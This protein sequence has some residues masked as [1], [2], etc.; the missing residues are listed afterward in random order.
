MS[1]GS[2]F[3]RLE[4]SA[5][6]ILSE[7]PEM[8]EVIDE[9]NSAES[10]GGRLEV[11]LTAIYDKL[12]EL[13]SNLLSAVI[14]GIIGWYLVKLMI[15]ACKKLLTKTKLEHAIVDFLMSIIRVFLRIVL[16]VI[17]ATTLGFEMSS[18]VALIASA[19]LAISLALQG[20]LTNFAGGLL[21]LATKPFVVGDYIIDGGGNEGK[22]TS[23]DIIYTHLLTPDNCAVVIPNGTLANSVIT[24][25]TREAVRRV[26][27]QVSID[28]SEDI[29]RVRLLL[30]AEAR[31]NR[32]VLQDH[33]IRSFVNKFDPSAID[34]TL[35]AWV[36][37]EDYWDLKFEMSEQI[38][39]TFDAN[40]I[41]IPYEKLDVNIAADHSGEDQEE[42]EKKEKF[43]TT[44]QRIRQG[45]MSSRQK[46]K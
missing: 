13:G 44:R 40:D 26:D 23:I 9:V 17:V 42:T 21:I 46:N 1:V 34:M 2:L 4:A 3:V 41:V 16:V 19:G 38:K 10:A 25:T 28:Y 37:S 6:S 24:N 35:R 30:E 15:R 31:K 29:E 5:E 39:K 45:R 18:F 11:I 8:S 22:V 43:P 36:K 7:M 32:Y 27:F 20:C 12:C 33:E 14:V